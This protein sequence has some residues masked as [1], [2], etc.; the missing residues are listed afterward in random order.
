MKIISTKEELVKGLNTVAKAVPQRTPLSTLDCILIDANDSKISLYATDNELGIETKIEGKIEE[1]GMVALNAKMLTEFIRSLRSEEI[2]IESDASLKT[3]IGYVNSKPIFDNMVGKLG[4]EFNKIPE[5]DGEPDIEITQFTLKDMISKTIFS[6][7]DSENNRIMTGELFDINGD[8][9]RVISMDGHRISIKATSLNK[10]SESKKIIIPAKALSEINKVISGSM[11]E[12]VKIFIN[13]KYAIFTFDET[14]VYTTLLHGEFFNV[15]Q[16]LSKDYTTSIK[17]NR[18]NLLD[19]VSRANLLVRESDKKPTIFNIS[20]SNMEITI[21]TQM[22]KFDEDV[23][24]EREGDDL[25]IGFNPKFL[26]ETLRAIDDEE[27]MMYFDGK[28][29]PVFI[30]NEEETY[31]YLVLPINI[32]NENY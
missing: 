14:K 2:V 31:I 28:I 23:E 9:L 16:M 4:E 8:K 10:S 29:S 22:A 20:E 19:T 1:P 24:I 17:V 13:Q 15:D 6:V 3:K 21:N 5:V 26:I 12:K 25:R 30:R 32:M 11:E 18:Q 27:I 7:S